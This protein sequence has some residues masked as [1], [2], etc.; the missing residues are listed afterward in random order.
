[1]PA[2]VIGQLDI[3]DPEAYQAYL[4]GFMP[5]FEKHGGELLAT[6]RAETEILEGSWAMPRTVIMRF[7]SVEKAKE[8]HSDPE[9]LELAKIRH[10]TASTN[11]AVIDGIA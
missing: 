7:P 2:Y 10:Q 4:G 9:Y 8:W 1:M 5:C 11:L 6:S 3:H